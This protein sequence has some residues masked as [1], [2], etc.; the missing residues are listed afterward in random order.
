VDLLPAIDIRSGRVVRLSQGQPALQ[1]VYSDDPLSV[2]EQFI[3]LGARWIHL[4]D[5][6][7]AFGSGSNLEVI[8]RVVRAV[9]TRVRVQLG[10]GLRDLESVRSGVELGATR[11]V[12]GTAAAMNPE[13]VP[14]VI[15]AVGSAPLAVGIDVRGG[16]VALRGWT[17]TSERRAEDLAGEVVVQGIE[18]VVYTDIARDGMLQGSDLP[19]AIA[20][21]SCGAGVVLSG[22]VTSAGEIRAAC[23]AGLSGVIVGRALYEGKFSLTEALTAADCHS[24]S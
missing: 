16:F 10:G 21:Q 5:L 20:L 19:G 11:V 24:A 9:R 2:A 7:R 15:Q 17:E 12:V 18:T 1:T 8:G 3:D 14:A 23:T 6:D 22:G 4:V 13:F